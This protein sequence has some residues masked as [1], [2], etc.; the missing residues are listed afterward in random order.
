MPGFNSSSCFEWDPRDWPRCTGWVPEGG[1]SPELD[2]PELGEEEGEAQ[3]KKE[4]RDPD[5]CDAPAP[6]SPAAFFLGGGGQWLFFWDRKRTNWAMGLRFLLALDFY[7]PVGA[8][9]VPAGCRGEPLPRK[10]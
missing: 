10:H 9:R 2:G 4:E 6:A 1:C 7:A 8:W 5:F 3:K